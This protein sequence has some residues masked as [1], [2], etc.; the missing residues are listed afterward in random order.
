MS[1]RAVRRVGL[2]SRGNE[3]VDI[4]VGG[5]SSTIRLA[6]RPSRNDS[7]L[8]LFATACWWCSFTDRMSVSPMAVFDLFSKRKKRRASQGKADVYQYDEIPERLR[9]QIVHI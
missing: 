3:K 2:P 6:Q 7:G 5:E 4:C 1:R 9:I 8:L